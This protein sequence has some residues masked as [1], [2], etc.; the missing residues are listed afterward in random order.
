MERTLYNFAE[1]IERRISHPEEIVRHIDDN[2]NLIILKR[3]ELGYIC[4]KGQS[5][6]NERVA[7]SIAVPENG[8]PFLT[9]LDFI[10]KQRPNYEIKS[11]EYSI[12]YYLDYDQFIRVLKETDMDFELYAL[13]RDKI[14][15]IPDEFEVHTC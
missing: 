13:L 14:K 6:F 11:L 5:R 4:K 1:N 2:Y 7:D 15:N 3:G 9:S 8:Q 12:I 10:T